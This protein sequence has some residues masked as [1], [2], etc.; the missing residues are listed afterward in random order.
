M[1][2]G[3]DLGVAPYGLE[4]LNV[5]RIE[6]GHVTGA[7]I[8]GRMTALHMGLDKMVSRKKDSIGFHNSQREALI[9]PNG[10]RLVGLRSTN[11]EGITA[12]AHLVKPN[13]QQVASEDEG[14][15]TS[16]CYSPM[17]KEHIALAYLNGG[18]KRMGE[19]MR[20][21]NPL[22]KNETPVEVVSAHFFDPTGERLR[23]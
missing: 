2:V 17:L 18:D 7:E 6:K 1:E 20:A 23:D 19:Q 15:V 3:A 5:M 11:G 16:V 10:P 4:A 22:Q 12:G 21:V 8:D 14:H 9:D 13:A